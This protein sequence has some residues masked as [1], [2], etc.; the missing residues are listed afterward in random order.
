MRLFLARMSEGGRGLSVDWIMEGLAHFLGTTLSKTVPALK[1]HAHMHKSTHAHTHALSLTALEGKLTSQGSSRQRT[2][3]SKG[4]THGHRSNRRG[5]ELE[6][7][8]QKALHEP[9]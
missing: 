4:E 1:E 7:I 9:H 8:G 2:I 3:K 6:R 5:T